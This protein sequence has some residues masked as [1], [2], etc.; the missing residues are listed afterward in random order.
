MSTLITCPNCKSQFAPEDAITKSLEKQYQQKLEAERIQLE[1]QIAQRAQELEK[2]EQDFKIKKENENRLFSERIEKEKQKLESELQERIRRSV[3][4]DYENHL[5][6]LQ[7]SN[8]DNEEKLRMA[9]QREFEFL[10]KEQALRSREEELELDFQKR[11]MDERQIITEE[12]RKREKTLNETKDSEHALKIKELEKQLEDQKRL[13]DEMKRKQEQGSM[14]LQGEVQEMALE[15]MLR[16]AFPFDMVD[17]VGKGVRGA[18][19]MQTVRN[20]MGQE[21]GKIIFESKRTENFGGEWIEKL[22]NDMRN[23]GAEI[24]VLVTR[25]MPKDLDCFGLKEG[26]WV[27]TFSEVKALVHVLRDG[28]IRVFNTAKKHENK[29]DKMHM[30]YDYLTSNE[31]NEQWKAIREG[32]I[33]MKMG[34]EKERV[35]M[36]KLWKAREKQLEKVLLNAAHFKGSIEGIAGSDVIDLTLTDDENLLD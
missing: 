10:Q 26:V 18:D 1:N 24:A 6:I 34:I 30:L 5:K 23:N 13:T 25:T 17:P 21:C 22:K 28:I 4:D 32:F 8:K 20:A 33:S 16:S 15:D 31:F 11:L 9:R 29:G 35:A 14:Q 27:C 19:C 36:E 3:K 2:L 12:I 7:Q